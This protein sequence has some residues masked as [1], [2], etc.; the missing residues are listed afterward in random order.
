MSNIHVIAEERTE[1]ITPS[2]HI[3][4]GEVEVTSQTVS[5]SQ[6]FHR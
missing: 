3:H 1:E 5:F 2:L 4:F 6:T